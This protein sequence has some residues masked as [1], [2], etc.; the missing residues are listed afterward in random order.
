MTE[1]EELK[2][3]VADLTLRLSHYEQHG[4]AKPPA[5]TEPRPNG[6]LT[7]RLDM[8][9]ERAKPRHQRNLVAIL[10]DRY[11]SLMVGDN[12]ANAGTRLMP[13]D[14]EGLPRRI[15]ADLTRET[16]TR[17]ELRSAESVN[18]AVDNTHRVARLTVEL[19][20]MARHT[21]DL[22]ASTELPP[23]PQALQVKWQKLIGP[24]ASNPYDGR[25]FKS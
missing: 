9:Y 22:L 15:A 18:G 25:A 5:S 2:A 21:E 12:L 20:A 7:S 8:A 10:A 6:A 23:I 24:L 19:A 16:I 3:Q 17:E 1:I 11:A 4:I 13:F 14:L